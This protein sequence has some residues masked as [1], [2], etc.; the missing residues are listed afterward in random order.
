MLWVLALARRS[1]RTAS[2]RASNSDRASPPWRPVPR[3]GQTT[4]TALADHPAGLSVGPATLS[5]T[6]AGTSSAPPK[7]VREMHEVAWNQAD[8]RKCPLSRLSG[9]PGAGAPR[10]GQ[11]HRGQ[12]GTGGRS[13][14]FTTGWILLTA[15]VLHSAT[16]PI[17]RG[18]QA[19]APE[20]IAVGRA[21]TVYTKNSGERAKTSYG[22]SASVMTDPL[23]PSTTATARR[24][25]S[26][27]LGGG[28]P[29]GG[30]AWRPRVGLPHRYQRPGGTGPRHGG[31]G[32]RCP[33]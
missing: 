19:S 10:S 5:S 7:A 26:T 9:S 31:T 29:S 33:A 4:L 27:G 16:R 17:L 22:P 11:G 3:N 2:V 18:P 23:A 8:P 13:A 28:Q 6:R 15:R 25:R 14:G 21:D 32:Q 20:S 30:R 12:Q 24:P 1:S